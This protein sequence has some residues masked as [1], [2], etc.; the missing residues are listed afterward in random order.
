MVTTGR[1]CRKPS[2]VRPKA[3]GHLSGTTVARRLV[4]PTRGSSGSGRAITAYLALL[5]LGVTVP[6]LL[7]AA[8]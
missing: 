6:R 5:R 8:R 7:P 3:D 2:S 4:R 1:S